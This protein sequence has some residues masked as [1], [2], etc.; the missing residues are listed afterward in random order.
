LT[1]RIAR[2]SDSMNCCLIVIVA[3]GFAADAKASDFSGS[4]KQSNEECS[5]KRTGD[6]TLAIKRQDAELVVETTSKGR[7]ERHALQRYTTDGV[8]SK[9]IGADGDEFYS[10]VVWKN[11]TL[12]FDIVE[13]EDGKRLKSM[14]IWSLMDGGMRLKRLRR[15]EKGGEQTLIYRRTK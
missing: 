7:I 10:T 14:E 6:V 4:W 12:V 11:G 13:V 1:F 5:P 2:L 9:S 8:E 15:S 3:L